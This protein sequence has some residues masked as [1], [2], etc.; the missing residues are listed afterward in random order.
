MFA[1]IALIAENINK[2]ALVARAI[3]MMISRQV[4]Q[5]AFRTELSEPLL[6]I[7][8]G[9]NNNVANIESTN[10]K[11]A[12]DILDKIFWSIA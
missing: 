11:L 2:L 10:S 1:S 12:G 4:G 8:T 9:S 5:S 3:A 6:Y 7:T